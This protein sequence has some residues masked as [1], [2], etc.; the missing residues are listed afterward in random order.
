MVIIGNK[1]IKE[2]IGEVISDKVDTTRTVLVKTVKVHPLYKKRFV[3]RRKYYAHDE[4]NVSK[5]G[6]VVKIRETA[7]ISKTKKWLLVEVVTATK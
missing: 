1:S 3:V 6:D 4:K 2:L 5:L 7:P